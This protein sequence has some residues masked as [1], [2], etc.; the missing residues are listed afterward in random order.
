VIRMLTAYAVTTRRAVARGWRSVSSS[1]ATWK[2][3]K[4]QVSDYA[5][6]TWMSALDLPLR[7]RPRLLGCEWHGNATGQPV[8][9]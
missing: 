2:R 8:A 9:E 6:P 3:H 5:W 4:S 1:S 7:Y